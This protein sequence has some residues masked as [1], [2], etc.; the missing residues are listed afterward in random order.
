MNHSYKTELDSLPFDGLILHP[1]DTWVW[2][3]VLHN[4]Q[5]FDCAGLTIG[6]S[7]RLTA[8]KPLPILIVLLS[9][10]SLVNLAV[11]EHQSQEICLHE[12]ESDKAI[13]EDGKHVN[14]EKFAVA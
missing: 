6:K 10:Q 7:V 5:S 8:N 3:L 11:L 4:S 9:K 1:S 2:L 13:G 12:G 14:Y